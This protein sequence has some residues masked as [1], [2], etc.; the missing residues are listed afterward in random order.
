MGKI[1]YYYRLTDVE[2]QKIIE[3]NSSDDCITF[4]NKMLTEAFQAGYKQ[5]RSIKFNLTSLITE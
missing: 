1:Q 3:L 5:G 4:I 2:K